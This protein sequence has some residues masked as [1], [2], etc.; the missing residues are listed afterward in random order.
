MKLI[1]QKGPRCLVWAAAMVFD[2][3]PEVIMD[4]V[5]HD[6]LAGIHMQELQAFAVSR[7]KVLAP[8]EPAPTLEGSEV[9]I[10]IEAWE[11]HPWMQHQGIILGQT[12][13]GNFHAV[14]WDGHTVF[15]PAVNPD[16]VGY[17]QFWM[18]TNLA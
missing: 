5:G 3:E 4:F 18:I 12:S 15:D 11:R 13:K 14:A 6:C 10:V 2:V 9:P 8:F 17:H 1:K 7:N 16:F